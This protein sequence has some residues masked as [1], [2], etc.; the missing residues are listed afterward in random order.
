MHKWQSTV[1]FSLYC[2]VPIMLV[3]N[4][5]DLHM[6]RYVLTH[7]PK[8]YIRS[9]AYTYTLGDQC[10]LDFSYY[11]C[12]VSHHFVGSLWQKFKTKHVGH[13]THK[14]KYRAGVDIWFTDDAG[15]RGK[16]FVQ[17]KLTV[18]TIQSESLQEYLFT[19]SIYTSRFLMNWTVWV[20][21]KSTRQ[22]YY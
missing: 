17:C 13:M 21:Q 12:I 11:F 22:P 5:N 20:S 10:S 7:T 16:P 15:R 19:G 14:Q 4:K 8:L 1:D 6:E 3:G 9:H 2:R 18:V